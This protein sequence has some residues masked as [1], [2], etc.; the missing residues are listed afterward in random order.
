MSIIS[1]SPLFFP[2]LYFMVQMSKFLFVFDDFFPKDET[3]AFKVAGRDKG[4]VF[5]SRNTFD[6][7]SKGISRARNEEFFE[8]K[9]KFIFW[10]EMLLFYCLFLHYSTVLS[11]LISLLFTLEDRRRFQEL[12]GIMQRTK[13]VPS[14]VFGRY[15][16]GS[17]ICA[18]TMRLADIGHRLTTP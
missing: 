17:A 6:M 5:V 9:R 8:K 10:L 3:Y 11:S 13:L 16:N 7:K 15:D 1:P 2:T 4:Q 18:D 12:R 14:L